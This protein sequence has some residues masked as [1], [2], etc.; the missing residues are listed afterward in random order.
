MAQ[1]QTPTVGSVMAAGK[2]RLTAAGIAAGGHEAR[3]LMAA[4][5]DQEPAA[6]V[7]R[8][9]EP[10]TP[11][12]VR[13]FERLLERR[14]AR[15]PLQYILGAAEF[16]SL[17]LAVTRDVLIPRPETELLVDAVLQRIHAKPAA[18]VAD[19]GTGSGAIA[20][21][22]AVQRPD[23][24]VQAVDLSAAALAVAVGNATAWGVDRQIIFHHGSWC[25]PLLT[26]GLVD[27]IDVVAANPPYVTPAELGH[28][29][30]EVRDHEPSLALLTLGDDPLAPYRAIAGGA[31]QLLAA[32]G[33]L[34]V[35]CAPWQ[36]VPLHN[37]LVEQG[38]AAV[39]IMNDYAGRPRLVAGRRP[40]VHLP[41][42]ARGEGRLNHGV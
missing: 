26:A 29:Q 37:W 2:R 5:L 6:L 23:V 36:A 14:G 32:S 11:D 18:H 42:P 7:C 39:E 38:W 40:A 13:R 19:L 3:V 20:V 4:V 31:A 30:P 33:W 12:Q 28:L 17:R 10:I 16:Y 8:R 15:E 35:E 1:A 21:A 25:E 41:A 27:T 9:Q 22:L 24:R 34:M